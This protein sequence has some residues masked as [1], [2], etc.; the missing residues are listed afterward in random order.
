V[1]KS[2]EAV[3]MAADRFS[4]NKSWE[5]IQN[6]YVGTGHGDMT[7]FEWLT[8]MHRDSIASYL[9]HNDMVTA[10]AVAKGCSV[11]RMKYELK[12]VSLM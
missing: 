5:H 6:K 8:S 11:G 10:M 9:G 1:C 7:K 2:F 3:E 12:M 4:I